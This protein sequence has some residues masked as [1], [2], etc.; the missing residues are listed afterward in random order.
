MTRPLTSTP[1][2]RD[3]EG[4]PEVRDSVEGRKDEVVGRL[5]RPKRLLNLSSGPDGLEIGLRPPT[6]LSGYGGPEVILIRHHSLTVREHQ[7]QSSSGLV[8]LMQSDTSERPI[9]S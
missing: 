3:L 9:G 6:L 1:A 2:G 7:L 5:A 4:E 8:G